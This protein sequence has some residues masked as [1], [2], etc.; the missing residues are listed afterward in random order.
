MLF[1]FVCFSLGF[2]VGCLTCCC[3]AA[4]LVRGGRRP[5][6]P[7]RRV[8]N[9]SDGASCGLDFS[10]VMGSLPGGPHSSGVGGGPT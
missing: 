5:F 10:R 9:R 3:A 2:W 4:C 8:A 6:D 1:L 7:S